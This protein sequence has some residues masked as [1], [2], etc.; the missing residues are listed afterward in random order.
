M[1]PLNIGGLPDRALLL[2]DT[3]PIVYV[4]EGHHSLAERFLPL[5]D[6]H[7][8]GRFRF[9]VTTVT[10]AEVLT[11]PLQRG[12]EGLATRYRAILQSWQVVELDADVAE[13]AARMRALLRLKLPDAVQ[14]ASALA[15]NADALVSYDRD[16][17]RV[18]GLNV[19]S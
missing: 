16:F 9:A 4:L 7:V 6:A 2:I 17:G 5:F 15:I 8:A 10:I 19:I 3:A 13:S 14:V 12:E 18:H 1:G 11:G